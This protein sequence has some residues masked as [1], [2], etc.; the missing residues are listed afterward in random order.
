MIVFLLML[1]GRMQDTKIHN[2]NGCCYPVC[3]IQKNTCAWVSRNPHTSTVTH[4]HPANATQCIQFK[5]K[6]HLVSSG[7]EFH[8]VLKVFTNY[9]C[10]MQMLELKQGF[11]MIGCDLR[12][13][14]LMSIAF[15]FY[16]S[17]ICI[18][19]V[20]LSNILSVQFS[21]INYIHIILQPSPPSIP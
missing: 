18:T 10:T 11:P 21:S 20:N 17:E 5:T 15:C 1:I 4:I 19:K 3:L 8:S 9:N 13:Y 14:L 6:A 12:L 16:C 7:H 2:E